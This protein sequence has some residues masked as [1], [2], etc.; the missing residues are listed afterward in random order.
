MLIGITFLL[1]TFSAFL[2]QNQAAL[3]VLTALK[4]QK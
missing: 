4:L 3:P 1:Y 2:R